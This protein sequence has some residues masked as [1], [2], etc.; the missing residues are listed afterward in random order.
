MQFAQR[1]GRLVRADAHGL[2]ESLEDQEL[3]LKQHLR[4]ADLE[5]QRKRARIEVLSEEERLLRD[6]VKR[7]EDEVA[8]LDADMHLA[9]AKEREELARF[10]IRKI[11]PRR[12]EATALAAR[13][14]EVV[15]ERERL[16]E[17][18]AT[19]ETEFQA[20]RGRVRTHLEARPREESP[21]DVLAGAVAEEEVEIELLRWKQAAGEAV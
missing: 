1:V 9:L 8:N 19:Q 3:L 15:E 6:E 11:I 18:L 16:V 14:A 7:L 5:L 21:G 13:I 10:A 2:I 20:L 4:E 17:R 12:R